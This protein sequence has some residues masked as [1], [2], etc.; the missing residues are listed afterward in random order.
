MTHDRRLIS[1]LIGFAVFAGL[2]FILSGVLTP[3]VAGMAVAYFFDPAADKLA[4]WGCSRGAA[5]GLII[6]AFFVL[7]FGSLILLAPLLQGQVVGLAS[8]IPGLIDALRIQ[9]EPLVQRLQA[10]MTPEAAERLRAAAG[11]YAGDLIQWLTVVLA[12]MWS[13]GVAFFQLLSLIVITPVVAFYLLRDWDIIVGRIDG[14]LP[15]LSAPTIRRQL[16]EIDAT[17]AGFVRGQAAVCLALAILYAV[18]LTLA[19]LPFGLLVGIGAGLISF[20]PYIGAMT[21]LVVGVGI[22][23]THFPDWP[24]VAVV[25]GVFFAGQIV[26]SYFLTPKLVGDRIGLHP[27]WIIFALLA[28]GALF[29]FTGIMLAIP[30]AAVIGVL[31]RFTIDRYQESA[32]FHGGD[33]GS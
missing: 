22:A 27:V 10:D 29:G 3:F 26:E 23:L 30:A 16:S 17:I 31:T 1:W 7:V 19:G 2:I 8:T 18:G 28:G 15:R 12:K 24:P 14:W 5:A 11:N 4:A 25:A 33:G 21:G 6:A 20:I 9:A 13:G 32:L